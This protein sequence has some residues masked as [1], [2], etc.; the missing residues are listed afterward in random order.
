MGIGS[1]GEYRGIVNFENSRHF[2][3]IGELIAWKTFSVGG[4]SLNLPDSTRDVSKGILEVN[5]LSYF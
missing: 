5:N 3:N 2:E 1:R 4:F